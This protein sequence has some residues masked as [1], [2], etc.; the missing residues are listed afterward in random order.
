MAPWQSCLVWKRSFLM[1][2]GSFNSS[3]IRRDVSVYICILAHEGKVIALIAKASSRCLH[4][5]RAAMLVPSEGTC[6]LS[7]INL[8]G[9][10][11][12]ITQKRCNSQT[13]D[14]LFFVTFEILSFCYWLISN[15]FFDGV[16]VKT[17]HREP[18]FRSGGGNSLFWPKRVCAAQQGMVF[19]VLRLK[20]ISLLNR[21]SFWTGSLENA[22]CGN[23]QFFKI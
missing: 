14:C 5:F 19:R 17:S 10:F 18:D 15:L 22:T 1:T 3:I 11:R 21:V 13:W 6:I 8:R 20:Q 12:Q 23:Q 16:T 7:S 2:F 9:T 4:W